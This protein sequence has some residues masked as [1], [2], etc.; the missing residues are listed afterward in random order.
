DQSGPAE[1][2][3][4]RSGRVLVDDPGGSIVGI[5]IRQDGLGDF[6]HVDV[7]MSWSD[8]QIG[9]T[10]YLLPVRDEYVY[11]FA[12]AQPRGEWHVSVDYMNHRHFEASSTIQ[13]K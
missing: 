2:N 1:Y 6:G 4:A 5:E 10:S 12:T 3:Q 9:D 11:R 7:K 8:V 13:F